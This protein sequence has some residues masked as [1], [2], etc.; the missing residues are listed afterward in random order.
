MNIKSQT[1]YLKLRYSSFTGLTRALFLGLLLCSSASYSDANIPDCLGGD[2]QESRKNL[3]NPDGCRVYASAINPSNATS[4]LIKLLLPSYIKDSYQNPDGSY[5]TKNASDDDIKLALGKMAVYSMGYA[6]GNSFMEEVTEGFEYLQEEINESYIVSTNNLGVILGRSADITSAGLSST[7]YDG[8]AV[9]VV[10]QQDPTSTSTVQDNAYVLEAA[11]NQI[12]TL[13]DSNMQ[14]LT[15]LGYSLGGVTARYALADMEAKDIDHRTALYISND[16]P[17]RGAYIPQAIQQIVPTM[18]SYSDDLTGI[19]QNFTNIGITFNAEGDLGDLLDAGTKF[20]EDAEAYLYSGIAQQLLI[21]YVGGTSAYDQLMAEISTMGYP[22][23]TYNIAISNSNELGIE[24]T[25]PNLNANGAFY[26]FFGKI[27]D[28]LAKR[29]IGVHFTLYP[30]EAGQPSLAANF[31]AWVEVSKP[32]PWP[33]N[34]MTCTSSNDTGVP[35]NKTTPANA[36]ELDNVPGSRAGFGGMTP[37]IALFNM[38]NDS[39]VPN[40]TA[41]EVNDLSESYN[42]TFVPAYSALDIGTNY[43]SSP[44]V[45]EESPFDATYFNGAS[46]ELGTPNYNLSHLFVHWPVATINTIIESTNYPLNNENKLLL[47]FTQNNPSITE[48]GTLVREALDLPEPQPLPPNYMFV[49]QM[50]SYVVEYDDINSIDDLNF[51]QHYEMPTGLTPSLLAA[52][53]S[54]MDEVEISPDFDGPTRFDDCMLR[55]DNQALCLTI[56][57]YY[58]FR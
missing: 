57:N 27:S 54:Q 42:F 25:P 51:S 19:L 22:Q 29:Y 13:R 48:I 36:K 1:P 17:H 45:I 38:T 2:D 58:P 26:E 12:N 39:L 9:L 28:D 34:M 37:E 11:I 10:K 20:K 3:L 55:Y 15:V 32:C 23:K 35:K 31:N 7:K 40:V 56:D 18:Q 8:F 6:S 52:M 16:A 4:G 43:P 33:L 41:V 47:W 44:L 50:L 49:P 24:E 30:T 5:D 21:D 46:A 14:D 53:K